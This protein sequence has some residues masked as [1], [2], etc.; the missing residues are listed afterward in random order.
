[1]FRKKDVHYLGIHRDKILSGSLILYQPNNEMT[2]VVD[3]VWNTVVETLVD[4][5]HRRF[6]KVDLEKMN[7]HNALA[8]KE[9]FDEEVTKRIHDKT[10]QYLTRF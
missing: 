2:E 7:I 5:S 1:M 3:A 9:R 4:E 10:N 6:G 8:R